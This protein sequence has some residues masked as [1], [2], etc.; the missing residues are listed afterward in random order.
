MPPASLPPLK[1]GKMKRILISVITLITATGALHAQEVK[2]TEDGRQDPSTIWVNKVEDG[3]EWRDENRWHDP[4]DLYA[5]PVVGGVAS[6]MTE[7]DGSFMFSP[8]VGGVLQVYFNNHFG[9]S[10]E[11]GFCR[12][13]VRNAWAN[14]LTQ[15]DFD[16]N[17]NLQAGPYEYRLDYLS[18]IYKLRY[19]PI[20]PVNIFAGLMMGVHLKA[21][22]TINDRDINIKDYIR[23]RAAHIIAG[24]G[25][26]MD[27]LYFEGYYGFPISKLADSD[28]GRKALHNAKEHVFMVTVGYRFKLY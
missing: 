11:F 25:Y 26:E 8:Y 28:L 12:Q 14:F 6:T 15:A 18:T 3:Q 5:G 16:E 24:L 7:Y 23:S 27:K 1:K 19:Y 13:G 4:F 2:Y 17:P 21:K 10:I 9:T 22:C 20:R